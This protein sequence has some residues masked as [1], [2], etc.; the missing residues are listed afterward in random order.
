MVVTSLTDQPTLKD[1]VCF[2]VP[3]VASKWYDIGILL[4]VKL[5]V[6]DC[7]SHEQER[8]DRPRELFIKWLQRSPG[9]GSQA[10]TWQSVLDAVDKICGAEAVEEIRSAVQSPKSPKPG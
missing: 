10:R 7:I 3:R 6:L 9:T 5:F 1:I 2:A 8:A 4:D